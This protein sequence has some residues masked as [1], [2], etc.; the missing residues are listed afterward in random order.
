[1]TKLKKYKETVPS[2]MT[3]SFMDII[4]I[5]DTSQTKKFVPMM[6]DIFDTIHKTQIEYWG[7]TELK[8]IQL[9]I[10][11]KIPNISKQLNKMTP[12][13]IYMFNSLLDLISDTQF[14]TITDFITQ[15]ENK[16]ILGVDISAISTIEEVENITTLINI[17]NISKEF[18]KQIYIDLDTDEWL[19]VRPLTYESSMKYG[20]NTK[21]CT[22][23]R[24]N[25]YQF[26][27]YT[28]NGVLGYCINRITGYKL[29]FHMNKKDGK[30]PYDISFWNS[31]DDR[32]DS[33][34][35]HID[36]VL[37]DLIKKIYFS[38]ETKTNKEIGGENWKKSSKIHLLEEQTL[39]ETE[40]IPIQEMTNN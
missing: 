6:V 15:Y 26:F 39:H 16:Q 31:A 4:E 8:E 12:Q 7:D 22:S 3:L 14:I 24:D 28:Q 5:V 33:M 10:Q 35:A 11:K 2:W 17:K 21:W 20:A 23:S 34:T 9:K 36:T 27:S 38:E 19:V 29:A 1:M 32:I 18:S 25:P 30:L 13:S 40:P 37:L